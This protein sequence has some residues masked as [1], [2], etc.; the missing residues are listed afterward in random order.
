MRN[1][2]ELQKGAGRQ[3]ITQA[4]YA[5]CADCA[6]EYPPSGVKLV[7]GRLKGQLLSAAQ[8]ADAGRSLWLAKQHHLVRVM[9]AARSNQGGMPAES[10]DDSRCS[11][12][13]AAGQG[14][15]VSDGTAPSPAALR[16]QEDGLSPTP[17]QG[18]GSTRTHTRLDSGVLLF[19]R[20]PLL[21]LFW[22]KKCLPDS[23]RE[24]GLTQHTIWGGIHWHPAGSRAQDGWGP[25]GSGAFPSNALKSVGLKFQ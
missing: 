15:A 22:M 5:S 18:G 16:A 14:R 6:A 23:V 21:S 3:R 1:S 4:P 25:G 11:V 7:K 20:F 2:Q 8:R 19:T 10:K 24:L 9:P 17:Q 12:N 13:T